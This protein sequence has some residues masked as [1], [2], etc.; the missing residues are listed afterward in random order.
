MFN[1]YISHN[2]TWFILMWNIWWALEY[3]GILMG[4]LFPKKD[5]FSRTASHKIAMGSVWIWDGTFLHFFWSARSYFASKASVPEYCPYCNSIVLSVTAKSHVQFCQDL[6]MSNILTRSS[7]HFVFSFTN[8]RSLLIV[9]SFLSS[10]WFLP[11][12]KSLVMLSTYW[13]IILAFLLFH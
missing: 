4:I 5:Y 10:F 9:Y 7:C 2:L 8:C 13:V 12:A 6:I 1:H 3:N 11:F